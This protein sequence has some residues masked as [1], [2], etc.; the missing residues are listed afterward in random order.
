MTIIANYIRQQPQHQTQLTEIY[1][2]ILAVVPQ[3][4]TEK[5]AYGMPTFY[6]NGNLVHFAAAKQHLGFYPTPSAIQRFS[7]E[8]R[9]FK[10]SP[11]EISRNSPKI[12]EQFSEIPS[13]FSE[14]NTSVPTSSCS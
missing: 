8:L 14:L 10:T 2:A 1:Q 12:K 4:T 5:I 6:L 13:Y 3:E 9:P 7:K 11:S